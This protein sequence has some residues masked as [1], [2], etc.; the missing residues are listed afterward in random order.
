MSETNE[1]H[2]VVFSQQDQHDFRA[3]EADIEKHEESF[4][5]VAQRLMEVKE[6]KF[7][8]FVA[9]TWEEYLRNRWGRTKQWAQQV[10]SS[11]EVRDSL[12]PREQK[13]VNTV[14]KARALK[15]VPPEQRAKVVEEAVKM[16]PN[17][18]VSTAEIKAAA[19]KVNTDLT[20]Q[21]SEKSEETLDK[22]RFPVPENLSTLFSRGQEVTQLLTQIATVR[23]AL[24]RLQDQKDDLWKPVNF[25]A[26][27][28][29]LTHVY[30]EVKLAVP[31]AVCPYCQGRDETRSHCTA[32][33]GR[34]VMS[35]FTWSTAV[36]SDIKA[37]REKS[38][39][40]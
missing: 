26:A 30:D 3:I 22:T 27:L 15:S 33:K 34:G 5:I 1:R 10:M 4:L 9:D 2:S 21:N 39:K 23:G 25:S 40:K 14:S 11:K 24:R 28:I 8:L 38:C 6:R 37:V 13:A 7:Y 18:E 31:Y 12:P 17:G 36:P 32:C 16:S 35:E 20:S 19:E 29:D